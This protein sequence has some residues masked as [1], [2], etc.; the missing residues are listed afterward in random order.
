MQRI[1]F[2]L[3]GRFLPGN[4]TGEN[5]SIDALCRRLAARGIA[6]L[7][8]CA[9]EPA[10]VADFKPPYDV[11]RVDEP[12]AAMLEMKGRLAPD[13]TLVC[14]L[15]AALRLA[16][17]GLVPEGNLHLR[18]GNV[19]YGLPEPPPDVKRR[20]RIAVVSRYLSDFARAYT[21]LEP[22]RIP[23]LFEPERYR[24]ERRGD[25]VLFV[26]PVAAKGANLVAAIAARLPH[27]RFLVVPSWAPHAS[28]PPIGLD[29]PNVEI[30]E[31]ALDMRV[32]LAR[33]RL[34]LVPTIVEEAWGRIVSEAQVS[35]IPAVAS[36]RGG[37]PETVGPGGMVIPLG[38]PIERWSAEIEAL[39]EDGPRYAALSAAALGHAARPEMAPDTVVARTLEFLAS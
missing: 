19:F 35:G 34:V 37:L 2:V 31:R 25:A 4:V 39:F 7:L 32:H 18:L 22:V 38:E 17:S 13:A 21:G 1:L 27:R 26:N 24:V 23:P 30:A 3:G 5:V 12:V 16:E 8:V 14:G 15:A 11:I 6:P 10:P 20:L 28:S 9:R 29:L 33:A 36:A